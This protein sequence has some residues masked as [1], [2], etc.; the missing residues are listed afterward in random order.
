MVATH[1]SLQEATGDLNIFTQIAPQ[2]K[3]YDY[4]SPGRGLALPVLRGRFTGADVVAGGLSGQGYLYGD[5]LEHSEFTENTRIEAW[6][7]LLDKDQLRVINDSESIKFGFYT[8]A[9]FS[10]FTMDGSD[11]ELAP[12]GY[13][14]NNP[15]FVSPRLGKPL[16]FTTI[17]ATNRTLP[18]MTPLE[19]LDHLLKVFDIRQVIKEYTGIEAD[20]KMAG[21]LV[22]YMNAQW[23][24]RFTTGDEPIKGYQ[25]VVTLLNDLIKTHS[26]PS[27]SSAHQKRRQSLTLSVK[28]AYNPS[29]SLTLSGLIN[30]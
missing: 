29:K 24:Y 16:S 10:G 11:Q 12:L 20:D 30:S 25:K 3:N 15:V 7:T 5:L 1:I 4:R 6:L 13:A 23:W 19:M 21:E 14:G 17:K 18:S 8:L 28:E 9:R 2:L 22:K 27:S 26:E